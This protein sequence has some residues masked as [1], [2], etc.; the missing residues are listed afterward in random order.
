MCFRVIFQWITSHSHRRIRIPLPTIFDHPEE[1][2][3]GSNDVIQSQSVGREPRKTS[4]LAALG[5]AVAG[6]RAENAGRRRNPR[7]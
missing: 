2:A 5:L 3:D 6:P 7:A 4:L 1:S